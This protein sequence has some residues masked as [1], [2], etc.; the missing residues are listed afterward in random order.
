MVNINFG[1][2]V[3]F[4]AVFSYFHLESHHTKGEPWNSLMMAAAQTFQKRLL[5]PPPPLPNLIR[6]F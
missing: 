4:A 5:P 2:S 3:G 1:G 6:G